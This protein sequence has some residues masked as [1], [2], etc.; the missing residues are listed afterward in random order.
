VQRARRPRTEDGVALIWT[1]GCLFLLLLAA[2][3][4]IDLAHAYMVGERAQNAADASA[5]AGTVFLPD[6][7]TTAKA[8]AVATATNNGFTA[9]SGTTILTQTAAEDGS[10]QPTQIRVEIKTSVPTLFARVV[11]F[12][13]VHLRREAVAD[14][15]QPVAMGSPSNTMGNQPECAGTCSTGDPNPQFWLNVAGPK[16]KKNKGDRHQANNCG[17]VDNC[18]G[19]NQDYVPEGYLFVV[20]N[21][22]EGSNLQIDV[23]DPAFVNVG[24]KCPNND[25]GSKLQ[26]LYNLTLQARHRWV[27]NPADP[28]DPGFPYCTG[29]QWF[30]A[31]EEDA[32]QG[33]Y[34][35]YRF[36]E[37]DVTP[38]DISD[39]V[40]I[41][42]CTKGYEPV[43]GDLKARY[44]AEIAPGSALPPTVS[45]YFRRWVPMCTI[46]NA[47]AGEYV[48]Q[49]LTNKKADGSN[50][51]VG[52]GHNR[53]AVRVKQN[54]SLASTGVRLYGLGRL[55][56]YANLTGS[57]TRFHLARVLPGAANR[58]MRI[59][60]FDVGDA[61]DVGTLTVLPPTDS[62][63]G[64]FSGCKYTAPPGNSSGPPFGAAVATGGGCS[65]SGVS[66]S[67]GWNGQ[68]VEWTVPIPADYTC[69]Y[70]DP[71]GCWIKMKFQYGSS[72]QVSDTTTWSATLDG[73]PVRIID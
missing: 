47:P 45:Q 49:V 8:R 3:F 59:V 19:T 73:N 31:S 42:S 32:T 61:S 56:I 1:G 21:E 12:D 68:I 10:L 22:V 27:A 25:R 51:T 54:G 4:A 44:Q 17:S 36:Y 57:D 14:Y 60:F 24:D 6:D 66:S 63:Y 71:T 50:V 16:S 30:N 7:A 65:V 41:G 39:N 38:E 69:N 48:V 43:Q 70:S 9:G 5:L 40:L 62:N 23:F 64:T 11:G 26:D 33:P 58:T 18:S 2:G 13:S 28:A 29:D 53:F 55:P 46:A 52:A 15:D 37:P 72:V 67:A 20:N 35:T 34:T